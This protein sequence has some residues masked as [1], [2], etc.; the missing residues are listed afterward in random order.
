M[1]PFIRMKGL[2]ASQPLQEPPVIDRLA[3]L[4]DPI[5]CRALLV[6]ERHELT[7]SELCAV[8]QLPQS[9]VSRHLKVLADD[10]LVEARK[11]GTSRRYSASPLP[12]E[13]ATGRL[14]SLVREDFA[15]N[16]AAQEDRRRLES[17][18]ARRRNRSKEFFSETAAD[19]AG[20]RRELFGQRFD[21]EAILGLL[22]ED[23]VVGDLGAGTGQLAA[24]LAPWVARVIAVDDFEPRRASSDAGE[25]VA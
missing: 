13:T 11:D 17:V 10:H 20:L 25:Q 22:D 14:W 8:L 6:L 18:L 19:W 23:W 15:G 12:P 3:T 1:Y 5:R 24:A 7:V 21:L 9:T 16:P 4:G 2:T